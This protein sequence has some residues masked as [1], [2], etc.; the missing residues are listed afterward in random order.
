MIRN[1]I[2]K[3]LKK[4][5]NKIINIKIL[6]IKKKIH[7]QVL[8]NKIDSIDFYELVLRYLNF[9]DKQQYV[10][11]GHLKNKIKPNRNKNILNP[12]EYL[13]PDQQKALPL[14]FANNLSCFDVDKSLGIG[15]DN[16][17]VEYEETVN[18]LIK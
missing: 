1:I 12:V 13:L 2:N 15:N 9:T 16:N 5:N 4:L 18:N 7:K 14:F 8:N 11:I 17:Q 6:F 10:A 3:L